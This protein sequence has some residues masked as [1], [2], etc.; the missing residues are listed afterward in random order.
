MDDSFG[1]DGYSI[2]TFL[3]GPVVMLVVAGTAGTLYHFIVLFNEDD[4]EQPTLHVAEKVSFEEGFENDRFNLSLVFD[5]KTIC[6][7]PISLLSST[8][9][10]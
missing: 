8:S 2:L 7:R 6:L 9:G 3:L 5:W 1:C 10:V 4:E